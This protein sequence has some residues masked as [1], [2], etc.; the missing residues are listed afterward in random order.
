MHAEGGWTSDRFSGS[1]AATTFRNEP[2]ASPGA[3]ASAARLMG[4]L[5]AGS[6]YFVTVIAP[7]DAL[8]FG[9]IGAP[10][11]MFLITG[12]GL[13]AALLKVASKLPMLIGPSTVTPFFTNVMCAV[14][15]VQ[16]EPWK[17]CELSVKVTDAIDVLVERATSVSIELL[18]LEPCH[19]LKLQGL[20]VVAQS[21]VALPLNVTAP[22]TSS[23]A[24][25]VYCADCE[26]VRLPSRKTEPAT[27][28]CFVLAFQLS[29]PVLEPFWDTHV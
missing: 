17:V 2:K 10:V 6:G 14:G 21:C 24:V 4:G 16:S 20:T 1:R 15:C 5:S 8:V 13:N 26:I 22:A 7:I 23:T 27:V 19:A 18:P 9:G 28:S 11:G 25:P 12:S 3:N 29:C